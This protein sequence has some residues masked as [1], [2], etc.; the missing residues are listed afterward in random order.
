MR[1]KDIHSALLLPEFSEKAAFLQDGFDILIK[2]NIDRIPAIDAPLTLESIEA[3]TDE[4]LQAFYAEYGIAEYYPDLSRETRNKMLF[5]MSKLWRFMGTPAAVEILCKYIFDDLDLSLTITDNLAF[6]SQ[7]ALVDPNSLDLFDVTIEPSTNSLPAD[8]IQRIEKNV[9]NFARN[10]QTIRNLVV[11]QPETNIDCTVYD[12]SPYDDVMALISFENDVICENVQPPEPPVSAITGYFNPGQG[13]DQMSVPYSW[14]PGGDN[15]EGIYPLNSDQGVRYDASKTYT[16]K[17]VFY[18]DGTEVTD[19]DTLNR[20]V[21]LKNSPFVPGWLVIRTKLNNHILGNPCGCTYEEEEEEE[22]PDYIEMLFN[23]TYTGDPQTFG[24]NDY[25]ASNIR[26]NNDLQ[27][28][29]DFG[30][31]IL[32]SSGSNPDRVSSSNSNF[33]FT[34]IGLYGASG[35]DLG[36]DMSNFYCGAGPSGDWASCICIW[37][38]N[39]YS[40]GVYTW[41]CRITK[42]S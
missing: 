15:Y 19:E 18:V 37:S 28:L 2:S 9:L 34:P 6:D 1:L 16:V 32:N 5:W 40:T 3:L 24:T 26:N 42:N 7:G 13:N 30:V 25:W 35:E 10:S 14:G 12:T 20:S 39:A 4:E 23:L 36:A 21:Q 29:Q 17:S 8:A 33:T 22:N 31:N 41:K 27:T 11:L 38:R